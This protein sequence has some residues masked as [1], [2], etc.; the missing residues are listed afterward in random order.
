MTTCSVGGFDVA[1]DWGLFLK[2]VR[3]KSVLS[4]FGQ[5]VA[6]WFGLHSLFGPKTAPEFGFEK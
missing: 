6:F 5:G 4:R 1:A 2:L 3:N